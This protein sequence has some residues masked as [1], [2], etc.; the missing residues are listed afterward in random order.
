VGRIRTTVEQRA[1]SW[2]CRASECL[3]THR[4]TLAAALERIGCQTEESSSRTGEDERWMPSVTFR[5]S[6]VLLT[7]I[8]ELVSELA[9]RPPS[10]ARLSHIWCVQSRPSLQGGLL[11]TLTPQ[12][13]ANSAPP[14]LSELQAAGRD[15]ETLA[16]FLVMRR[17]QPVENASRTTAR[18]PTRIPSTRPVSEVRQRGYVRGT[19]SIVPPIPAGR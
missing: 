4:A 18:R 19:L 12:F 10:R 11:H 8:L 1:T 17:G 16:A 6:G 7:E 3:D 13:Q 14:S 5:A 15:S 9:N 2:E